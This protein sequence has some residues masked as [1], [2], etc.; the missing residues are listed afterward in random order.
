M[1]SAEFV[2]LLPVDLHAAGLLAGYDGIECETQQQELDDEARDCGVE[3]EA[4]EAVLD[5]GERRGEEGASY[6]LMAQRVV[7]SW[8]TL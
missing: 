7:V 6:C 2:V 1:H 3:C 5:G 8:H 4:L